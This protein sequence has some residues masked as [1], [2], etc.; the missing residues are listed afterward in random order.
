M[1]KAVNT[2][3]AIFRQRI[4]KIK[5]FASRK[6][7]NCFESVQKLYRDLEDLYVYTNKAETKSIFNMSKIF[8]KTI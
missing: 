2:E 3:K 5:T 7:K 1:K 4:N 6:L 8:R